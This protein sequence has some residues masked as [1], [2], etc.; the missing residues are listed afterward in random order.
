MPHASGTPCRSSQRARSLS[1][2]A[3]SSA[4]SAPG[5]HGRRRRSSS[6]LN[7]AALMSS[8]AS[9][10]SAS[11]NAS[12][13]LTQLVD[14]PARRCRGVVDL[15][16][17]AGRQRPERHQRVALPHG[18]LDRAS[19]V[20]EPADQVPGEGEPAVDQLAQPRRVEPQHASRR[21]PAPRRQIDAVVVPRPEAAGPPAGHVHAGHHDVL[22]TDLA[23]QVERPCEQHPPLVGVLTLGEDDVTGLE[24]HLVATGREV[25][26]LVVG[27]TGEQLDAAQL[28]DVH[29]QTVAR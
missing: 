8:C 26:E 9:R 16:R 27:Q 23:D 24:R 18:R 15:V 13:R 28:L 3:R 5:R 21:G 2:S 25:L 4:S 17:E 12:Q 29:G 19:G 10:V 22:T 11:S 14:R 20:V 6:A 1:R 7:C